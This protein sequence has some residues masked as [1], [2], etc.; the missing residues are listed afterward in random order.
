MKLAE[1]Q[2]WWHSPAPPIPEVPDD[3]GGYVNRIFHEG[4]RIRWGARSTSRA[5]ARIIFAD[6]ARKGFTHVELH[7]Y[8]IPV[9]SEE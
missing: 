4:R 3:A 5:A 1:A 9:G 7:G 8:V 2:I 6:C